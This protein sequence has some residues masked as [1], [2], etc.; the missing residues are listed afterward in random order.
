MLAFKARSRFTRIGTFAI[1]MRAIKCDNCKGLNVIKAGKILGR[2]RYK[3]KVCLI[4][5]RVR[6]SNHRKTKINLATELY[7]EGMPIRGIARHL[8]VSHTTVLR[9]LEKS[10]KVNKPQFPLKADHI[11]IDELYLYIKNKRRKYWL[12]IA[13]CRDTKRILG[14]QVGGRNKSTLQK[15]YDK[16]SVVECQK[17]Y[18]DGHAPYKGVLPKKKHSSTPGQT[19]TIEGIN[20]AIR[21]YLA[22]FRRRTKCYSKSLR[23]VEVTINLLA[24]KFNQKVA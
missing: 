8:K 4:H 12:W 20:S 17:Y 5:F 15:L 14:F 19:N 10:E 3:C 9:W 11:E 18:T 21:H 6:N 1:G 2:Q 23:M 7:L 16:L 22:R 24:N 13:L